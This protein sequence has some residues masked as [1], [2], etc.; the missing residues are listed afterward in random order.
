MRLKDE[1][2]GCIM[3]S[4]SCARELLIFTHFNLKIS[5]I[6]INILKSINKQ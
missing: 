5:Y 3:I 1:V 4:K 2:G 6:I